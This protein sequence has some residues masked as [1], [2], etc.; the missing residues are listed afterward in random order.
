MDDRE[1][2]PSF[3][4]Q[5]ER[6]YDGFYRKM[7]RASKNTTFRIYTDQWYILKRKYGGNVAVIVRLLLDRFIKGELPDVEVEYN[8]LKE[9]ASQSNTTL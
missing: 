4:S 7:G 5:P 6:I 2:P 9:A 3:T 8:K 1:A